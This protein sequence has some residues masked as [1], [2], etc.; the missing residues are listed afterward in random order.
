[1]SFK[2]FKIYGLI[3]PE[4]HLVRYVGKTHQPLDIRYRAHAS[5]NAPSTADW[6]ATLDGPPLLVLLEQGEER[7]ITGGDG[8]SRLRASSFAEAK[9]IKRFRRTLVNQHKREAAS[10]VWD[11]LK[12]PDT[13][14]QAN[15]TS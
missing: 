12:N 7:M 6:I 5:G 9:W 8:R 4:T 15:G 3:E 14:G 11:W 13:A 10:K 1:M 2:S